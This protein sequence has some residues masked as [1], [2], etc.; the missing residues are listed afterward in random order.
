MPAQ[1]A[2]PD[3]DRLAD[4]DS[5]AAAPGIS[6]VALRLRL[7]LLRGSS[8]ALATVVGAHGVV[9]RR[10]GT[11]LVVPESGETIGFSPRGCLDGAIR[12]LAAE[13]LATG[14]SRLER[15]E[16]DQDAAG[17]IGLSGR[18]SLEV[19][20][21]RVTAPDP[22]FGRMLRYL[23]SGDP[24]VVLMGIRGVSGCAAVGPDRVAGRLSWA[25]LP[26]CV[27]A[28]ARR[29]LGHLSYARKHYRRGGERG[30]DDAEV[31]MES[32]PAAA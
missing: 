9:V 19:H 12:D 20:A 30:R 6:D 26:Q 11:V 2:A 7:L 25:E 27:I 16:I 5:R 23:D 13:V 3:P 32:H 22:C 21:M 31:W 4:L 15:F 10:V 28:D 8:F 29:M 1:P 14:A 24:L 18:I 17:Y